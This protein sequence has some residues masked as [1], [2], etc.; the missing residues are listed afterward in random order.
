[1]APRPEYSAMPQVVTIIKLLLNLQSWTESVSLQWPGCNSALLL[2]L[3]YFAV[4]YFALSPDEF[5]WLG[6]ILMSTDFLMSNKRASQVRCWIFLK[7][8]KH[9][10]FP[11]H[12]KVGQSYEKK[13]K[14]GKIKV[15][16][17][18]TGFNPC[19]YVYSL[20]IYPPRTGL[21]KIVDE[22]DASLT[23]GAI[24]FLNGFL[25]ILFK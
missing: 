7:G 1:M 25:I 21:N 11:S 22:M 20:N 2:R 10:Y 23:N 15:H 6:L 18:W 8:T 13:K 4:H 14:K 16:K 12:W 3:S 17:V 5:I 19:G 24:Y 9:Y